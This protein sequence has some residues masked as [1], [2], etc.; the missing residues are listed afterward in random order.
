M[1]LVE[2][3]LY[4]VTETPMQIRR[5]IGIEATTHSLDELAGVVE[6]YGAD[7]AAAPEYR[8]TLGTIVGFDGSADGFDIP[9]I[10]ISDK[11]D[12]VEGFKFNR[13]DTGVYNFVAIVVANPINDTRSQELQYIITGYTSPAER[14]MFGHLPD[15]MRF[16]INDIYGLQAT[17]LRDALGGRVIDPS[18]YRMVENYILSQALVTPTDHEVS[19]DVISVA[20]SASMINRMQSSADVT[21]Q[22]DSSRFLSP[23]ANT[24][25]QLMTSKLTSPVS[26]VTAISN[27]S[28]RTIGE[29]NR[30]SRTE[31]FFAGNASVDLE[32]ELSGK[33]I[34]RK[35]SNYEFVTALRNALIRETGSSAAGWETTNSAS[36]RLSDLR[37]A[38]ENSHYVDERIAASMTLADRRRTTQVES[39]D[40]WTVRNGFA[41]QAS[42]VAYDFATQLGPILS[43]NL[44]GEVS[45]FY[46]NRQT[47][48]MTPPQM[49]I[50]PESVR[51]L[52]RGDLPL[53]LAQRARTDLTALAVQVTKNN[54][55]A[56]TI[57]VVALLG[58]ITRII[59]H[60]DGEPVP[61][62]F[63]YAS[64]MSARL[65]S[66]VSTDIGYVGRLAT[67]TSK[68]L[69]AVESG[70]CGFERRNGQQFMMSNIPTPPSLSSQIPAPAAPTLGSGMFSD[71]L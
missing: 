41:T 65:H 7:A 44:I 30:L 70:Y 37:M 16:F 63:T 19:V 68:L 12:R 49:N 48:F 21:F 66:G 20:K 10:N 26:F 25:P 9:V 69:T 13:R 58:T 47:D 18:G 34:V 32:S 5:K 33:C 2:L 8:E 17:Y 38:V 24:S 43:R 52:I 35:F 22:P 29:D 64:F 51:T 57:E 71:L 59:V 14:S 60:V 40:E 39:T 55:I 45:M 67:E 23:T 50:I 31:S 28:L 27:A 46:D 11:A 4:P 42:L 56:C 61:E 36:F 53:Q 62:R 3:V 15:D 54:R 6:Q 1:K